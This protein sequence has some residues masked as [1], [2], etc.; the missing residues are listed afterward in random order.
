MSGAWLLWKA[1]GRVF[2]YSDWV[3]ERHSIL[4]SG[5]SLVNWA[6]MSLWKFTCSAE[7]SQIRNVVCEPPPL[8][9]LE[10]PHADTSRDAMA[11]VAITAVKRGRGIMDPPKEAEVRG[12]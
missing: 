11:A 5:C 2:M 9:L 10:V 3:I 8:G 12:G 1:R 6:P 4:M 7:K